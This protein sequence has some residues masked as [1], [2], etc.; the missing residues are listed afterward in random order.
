[1]AAYWLKIMPNFYPVLEFDYDCLMNKSIV[2]ERRSKDTAQLTG[3]HKLAAGR[4]F[5]FMDD[6]TND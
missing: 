5:R 4:I 6:E 3:R 2:D 1:M